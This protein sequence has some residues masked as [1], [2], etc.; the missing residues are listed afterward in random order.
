MENKFRLVETNIALKLHNLRLEHKCEHKLLNKVFVCATYEKTTSIFGINY[1]QIIGERD[2]N[3]DFILRQT[4][5]C[6]AMY[7]LALKTVI[8]FGSVENP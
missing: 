4:T 2:L 5:T 7:S 3:V 1:L 6:F 8:G